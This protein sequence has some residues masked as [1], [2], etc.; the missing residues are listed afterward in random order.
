MRK[1]KLLIQNTA[2][3]EQLQNANL[4]VTRLKREI[5]ERDAEIARLKKQLDTAEKGKEPT[6]LQNLEQKLTAHTSVADDL[7]YG[8]ETIGKIVV[9]AARLSN[10]L[11]GVDAG[12]NAKELVNLILGRT[13]VAKSEILNIVSSN[14][15]FEAKRKA[16]DEQ[17]NMAIE[18]FSSVMA[19]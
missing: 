10:K 4:S 6:P 12:T 3:F 19:Q 8:A 9:E 15:D 18:Y 17:Y 11:T 13:E 7:D 14:V 1:K 16:I 5:A 2:L